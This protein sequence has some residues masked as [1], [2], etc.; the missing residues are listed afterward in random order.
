MV[1][2]TMYVLE[3]Q[4]LSIFVS[5]CDNHH[6]FLFVWLSW[7]VRFEAFSSHPLLHLCVLL[8]LLLLFG[9]VI[10]SDASTMGRLI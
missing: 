8:E 6:S 9:M 2:N 1:K 5:L 3:D 4:I 10:V 7:K